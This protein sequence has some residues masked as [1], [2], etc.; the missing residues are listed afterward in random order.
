MMFVL[1]LVLLASTGSACTVTTIYA[2]DHLCKDDLK[3][4]LD[5]YKQ[6]PKVGY[7]SRTMELNLDLPYA[8]KTTPIDTEFPA[9]FPYCRVGTP[10]TGDYNFLSIATDL[11]CQDHGDYM[12]PNSRC[13]FG[14]L[15]I[16]E[17]KKGEWTFDGMNEHGLS[18]SALAFT[19]SHYDKPEAPETVTHKVCYTEFVPWALSQFKTIDELEIVMTDPG[20]VMMDVRPD[21]FGL[22]IHWSVQDATGRDVVIEYN[23]HKPGVAQFYRN[24]VGVMTNNPDFEWHVMNLNNYANVNHE[25]THTEK[26]I[27]AKNW[28]WKK[29]GEFMDVPVAI[30][31]G[32]NMLGLPGNITPPGRFVKLFFMKQ[33]AV[34][35]VPPTTEEGVPD[36][37]LTAAENII[38][39]VWIPRG[40]EPMA[41]FKGT[42]LHGYTQWTVIKI[43]K[44]RTFYYKG[45]ADH[46]LKMVDL[47]KLSDAD[48]RA[49]KRDYFMGWE[50]YKKDETAQFQVS[51]L[52]KKKGKRKKKDSEKLR[53][54]T[55]KNNRLANILARWAKYDPANL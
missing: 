49:G 14:E 11:T 9:D 18:I 8:L 38:Q 24:G 44:T 30:G 22:Q 28:V 3:S 4:R 26:D 39:S 2:E 37:A 19:H 34:N 54:V 25:E 42:E 33:F 55:N 10:W 15:K 41:E 27:I 51:P 7:T 35:A 12:K 29:N 40:V 17:G 46:R 5:H 13:L 6:C 52:R 50:N 23:Y 43:P 47:S 32:A 36:S 1:G 48:Y 45:Y 53:D 21:R 16:F 31:A 20:F